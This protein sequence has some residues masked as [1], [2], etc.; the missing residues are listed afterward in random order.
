MAHEAR[1]KA[2]PMDNNTYMYNKMR[3]LPPQLTTPRLDAWRFFPAQ[4]QFRHARSP[5]CLLVRSKMPPRRRFN[6][7]IKVCIVTLTVLKSSCGRSGDRCDRCPWTCEIKNPD[8]AK[9]TTEISFFTV[10]FAMP[11]TMR[12]FNTT[13]MVLEY[14]FPNT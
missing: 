6:I 7:D 10:L 13:I 3:P 9:V 8:F 2:N 12:L 11:Y 5:C 4:F 1:M 14:I